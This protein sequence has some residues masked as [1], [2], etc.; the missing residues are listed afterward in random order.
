MIKEQEEA[1]CILSGLNTAE[2]VLGNEAGK[3]GRGQHTRAV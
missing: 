3:V 2:K 1:L